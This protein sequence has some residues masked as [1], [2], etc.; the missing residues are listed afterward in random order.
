MSLFLYS[1]PISYKLS[2]IITILIVFCLCLSNIYIAVAFYFVI[3]CCTS[4]LFFCLIHFLGV[5]FLF[6][7][8]RA[9]F[10]CPDNIFCV[11]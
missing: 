11:V 7:L 3:S 5:C 1:S 6:R 4:V 9:S 8:I 2:F 10:D